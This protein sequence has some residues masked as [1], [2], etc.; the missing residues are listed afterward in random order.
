M[1]DEEKIEKLARWAGFTFNDD[2][3]AVWYTPGP[4]AHHWGRLPPDFLHSLDAQDRWLLPK[5]DSILLASGMADQEGTIPSAFVWL[6][7]VMKKR[8]GNTRAEAC[9][10][11]VLSLIDED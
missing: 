6:N 9:A 1:T 11:A 10:D 4:D 5:L 2:E 8:S 7:V 3:D